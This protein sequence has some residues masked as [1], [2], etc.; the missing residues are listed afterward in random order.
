MSFLFHGNIFG[1][2]KQDCVMLDGKLYA[3]YDST[4]KER[5]LR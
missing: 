2:R 1:F 3:W 4:G 5:W